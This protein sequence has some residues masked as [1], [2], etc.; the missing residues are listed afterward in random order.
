MKDAL[1]SG[2]WEPEDVL[3][4]VMRSIAGVDINPLAVTITRANYLFAL[5]EL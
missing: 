3:N 1:R 5:R 2:G 4:Y